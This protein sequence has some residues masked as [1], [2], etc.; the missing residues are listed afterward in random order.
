MKGS[1]YFRQ[2]SVPLKPSGAEAGQVLLV[3]VLVIV[4]VL[5]VGLSLAARSITNLKQTTDENSSQRA[6][7]A[8]EA[9]VQVALQDNLVGSTGTRQLNNATYTTS[10]EMTSG[11]EFLV[12]GGGLLPPNEAVDL[13]L[14]TYPTYTDQWYGPLTIYYGNVKENEP[15]NIAALE[16]LVLSGST[17]APILTQYAVDQCAA[18]R[19]TPNNFSAPQASGPYRVGGNEY[20]YALTVTLSQTSPGILARIIPL[21]KATTMAVV[22]GVAGKPLPVQGKV[23]KSVG[24]AGETKRKIVVYQGFPKPPLELFPYVLFTPANTL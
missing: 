21:Y 14:S 3:V 4:I 1:S 20:K 8:A 19:Q 16:V 18:N 2:Q 6:F 13:W 17:T 23:I 10:V 12:N 5:T 24:S 7:S 11:Q 9:G 22:S 15:C